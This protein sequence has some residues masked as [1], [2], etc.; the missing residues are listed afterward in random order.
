MK[1]YFYL[2]VD[3]CREYVNSDRESASRLPAGRRGEAPRDADAEWPATHSSVCWPV[4]SRRAGFYDP[5]RK[6][7]SPIHFIKNGIICNSKDKINIVQII[8][9]FIFKELLKVLY[10]H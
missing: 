3:Q 9:R 7:L 1:R 10:S 2:N 5:V 8:N 4:N 6:Q